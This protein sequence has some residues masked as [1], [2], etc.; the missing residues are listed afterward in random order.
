MSRSRFATRRDSEFF[1]LPPCLK[2]A[3]LTDSSPRRERICRYF[4]FHV[5]TR[6]TL[7]DYLREIV[8]HEFATNDAKS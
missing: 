8:S 6:L 5:N 3:I 7:C 4:S 1:L 2:P